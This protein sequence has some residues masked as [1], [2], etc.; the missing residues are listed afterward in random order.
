MET[1]QD[2]QSAV[3]FGMSFFILKE[4]EKCIRLLTLKPTLKSSTPKSNLMNTS[5]SAKSD[6][7]RSRRPLTAVL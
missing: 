2:E 6:M 4:K 5:L 3:C 1:Y 7:P